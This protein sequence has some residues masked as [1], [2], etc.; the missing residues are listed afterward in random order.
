MILFLHFEAINTHIHLMPRHQ[1]ILKP[2]HQKTWN[3]GIKQFLAKHRNFSNRK[4]DLSK[5]RKISRPVRVLWPRGESWGKI[6]S[7]VGVLRISIVEPENCVE[8]EPTLYRKNRIFSDNDFWSPGTCGFWSP[9]TWRCWSPGLKNCEAQ[10]S[11]KG[12][13][14][15][16]WNFYFSIGSPE[17]WDSEILTWFFDELV[18]YTKYSKS[19]R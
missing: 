5:K 17:S 6:N 16:F 3:P 13:V 12:E 1:A 2:R 11:K 19:P 18:A 14:D 9:A 10:A 7:E 8:N 4:S 15:K